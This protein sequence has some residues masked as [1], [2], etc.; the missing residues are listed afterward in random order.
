MFGGSNV[1][2]AIVVNNTVIFWKV[3]ERIDLETFSAYVRG[4]TVSATLWGSHFGTFVSVSDQNIS[5]P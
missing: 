3:A 4:W 5:V 1:Q 2:M